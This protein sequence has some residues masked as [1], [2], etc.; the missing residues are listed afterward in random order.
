MPKVYVS[1]STQDHNLG[2]G[3]YGTE[4]QEMN[5]I[6][7]FVCAGLTRHGISWRRN[8]PSMDLTQIGSDSNAYHPD[9]HVAIHSNA[10]GGQGTEAWAYGPG[11]NAER[12]AKAIYPYVSALSPGADRGIKFKNTFYETGNS[13]QATS[14]IVEVGFHDNATDAADIQSRPQAYGEAFVHGI[15]DYFGIKYDGGQPIPAPQPVPQPQPAPVIKH[16][17]LGREDIT[18]D[19][20]LQFIR[21]INPGASASLIAIY[22]KY[23]EILGITWG[24]AVAQMIKETN[25]LRFTGDVHAGQ[26]NFAGLGAVGGGAQGA[27]F[28][29]EDVGVLAQMEHAFGYATTQSLPPGIG[30]VDPRFGLLA[31]GSCP[32][33]EDLNGHWAVPGDGYGESIIALYEKM[34]QEVVIPP[35]IIPPVIDSEKESLKVQVQQLQAK[36]SQISK[37]INS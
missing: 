30:L 2:V 37:I 28:P 27:S 21:K 7:D 15:C 10:G 18:V 34:K 22:K 11:T 31:R 25:Y 16:S 29:S 23:G 12:L 1:P 26:N 4:E 17:I 3:G 32:N 5:R 9:I 6:A 33:W 36:L 13:I 35:V 24:K 14:C 19:Q 8:N 20:C